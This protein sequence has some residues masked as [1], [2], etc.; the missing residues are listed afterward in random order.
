LCCTIAKERERERE[1]KIPRKGVAEEIPYFSSFRSLTPLMDSF[2]KKDNEKNRTAERRGE[3]EGD[4]EGRLL[5][6][7]RVTCTERGRPFRRD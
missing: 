6:G 1:R 4:A 2:G 5:T 3:S 7:L